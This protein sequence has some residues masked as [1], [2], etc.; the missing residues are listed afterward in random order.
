MQLDKA[1][2]KAPNIKV[3]VL[4]TQIAWLPGIVGFEW[5]KPNMRMD[6]I[7]ESAANA[8]KNLVL[9]N[10]ETDIYGPRLV[11]GKIVDVPTGEKKLD[12]YKGTGDKSDWILITKFTPKT[13]E[14]NEKFYATIAKSPIGAHIV[15]RTIEAPT[16]DKLLVY[17]EMMKEV[18]V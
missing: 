1:K 3:E 10:H 15:G 7:F 2:D 11:D 17:A 6:A 16:Y 12:G 14:S 4:E 9:I 5:A 8:D 18:P 13:K